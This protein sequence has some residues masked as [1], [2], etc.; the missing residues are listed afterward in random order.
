MYDKESCTIGNPGTATGKEHAE[1]PKKQSSVLEDKV[2]STSSSISSAHHN[3]AKSGT[4]TNGNY[5]VV[6]MKLLLLHLDIPKSEPESKGQASS[7][8]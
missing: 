4:A 1:V 3:T 2:L 5:C 8:N 6:Y 7:I